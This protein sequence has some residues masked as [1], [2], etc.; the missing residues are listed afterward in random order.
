[1]HGGRSGRSGRAPPR[2][3]LQRPSSAR[4]PSRPRQTPV[5]NIGHASFWGARRL[6]A[7]ALLP[8]SS[9]MGQRRREPRSTRNLER[10]VRR[11]DA[12]QTPLAKQSTD[13]DDVTQG[14]YVPRLE[15]GVP[16]IFWAL[17]GS[18]PGV[19]PRNTECTCEPRY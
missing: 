3:G 14:G 2:P 6:S 17:T 10:C 19:G 11:L 8:T 5:V 16:S 12:E 18:S 15:G 7:A 13:E 9:G 1:M 4:V